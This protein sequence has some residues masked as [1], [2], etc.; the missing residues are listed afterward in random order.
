MIKNNEI[1]LGDAYK[2]IK[3]IDDKSIDCI[4]TDVPYLYEKNGNSSGSPLGR[5]ITRRNQTGLKELSNGF[6]Y[7]ILD[8]FIRVLKKINLFIWCSKGQLNDLLNYFKNIPE[9]EIYNEILV[10]CKTN[11]APLTNNTW[12]PDIEYCLYFREGGVKLN[13]DYGLKHKYYFG[14][15]NQRDK[16]LYG[17]PTIKPVDLVEKH[18]L[19]ATQ[20]NDIILDPFLGSG[21]TAVACKEIGRQ[22]IG[23]EISEEY[24]NIAV[25]RL[26]GITK[27]ERN[28]NYEQLNLW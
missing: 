25:N 4:Y 19:H 5:R 17:H 1:Y 11:P 9:R 27:K 24:Y 6:D 21:T 2:L 14:T 22:Y 7:E 8:E 18:L 13:N 12:L 15:I 16:E 26:K 10:W 28:N 20:E 3:E 23:F